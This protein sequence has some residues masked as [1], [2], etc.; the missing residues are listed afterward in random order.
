MELPP[1]LPNPAF[2]DTSF[3]TPE[4]LATTSEYSGTSHQQTSSTPPVLFTSPLPPL[5]DTNHVKLEPLTAD[6]HFFSLSS[7]FSS[8]NHI[9]ALHPGQ[10]ATPNRICNLTLWADG[11]MPYFIDIDKLVASP[12]PVDSAS[13]H[14]PSR[15]L[16]R[17]KL[18]LP[19]NNQSSDAH[20]Q[21]GLDGAVSF[22]APW[23]T[24][25]HCH[26][27]V[28]SGGTC[29]IKE[30][31]MLKQLDVPQ[32]NT[33]ALPEMWSSPPVAAYL[34]ESPL[35]R[36]NFLDTSTCHFLPMTSESFARCVYASC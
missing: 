24:T 9:S 26:T 12:N 33:G 1:M 18:S 17:V 6:S 10:V 35:S 28:W 4:H 27:K 13:W 2:H 16:L 8:D 15:I 23:R 7:N 29:V 3:S 21:R 25:A 31:R 14:A 32:E 30:P 36:C 20:I 5:F 19:I 11:G 34:P 22:A